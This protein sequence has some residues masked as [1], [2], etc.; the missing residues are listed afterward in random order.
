M[1]YLFLIFRTRVWTGSKVIYKTGNNNLKITG[2]YVLTDCEVPQWNVFGLI[3]FYKF[4]S[5][6]KPICYLNIDCLILLYDTRLFFSAGFFHDV[7][8]KATSGDLTEKVIG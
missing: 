7:C 4:I 3:N 6:T 5:C 2:D 1:D 8:I